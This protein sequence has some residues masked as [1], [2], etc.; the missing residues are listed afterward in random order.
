[1]TGLE[2]DAPP[3][4]ETRPPR[5]ATLR[6]AVRVQLRGT[7]PKLALGWLLLVVLVSA[8]A[9]FVEPQNPLAQHLI[10]A[11]QGPSTAHWLGTDEYGRDLL[12]RLI[13]GGGYLL[14]VS[15]LPVAISFG[16][17]V[18][19]GLFAGYVGGRWD[20][21]ASFYVNVL[22]SVPAMVV[23]LATAAVTNQSLPAMCL[24][25][26]I[27]GTSGILRISR[28]STLS[29]RDLLYV[30]AARVARL[31]RRRILARHILPNAAGPLLVQAFLVYS[32]TVLFLSSLAFLQLGFDPDK[33]NWGEMAY[34]ASEHL[35]NDPW[36]MVPIGTVL[37]L[38]VYSVTFLGNRLLRALP[39]A[40]RV[41]LLTAFAPLDVSASPAE[42]PGPQDALLQVSGL[43]VTFP[44]PDGEIATVDDVGFSVLRG[45]VLG[46]VGE[47]GSGKS[48]IGRALLGLVEPAAGTLRLDGH[49]LI[50]DRAAAAHLL[51]AVFQD[52]YSSLNPARTVGATLTEP[53]EIH[54]RLAADQAAE[55][56]SGLLALVAL[57]ADTARRYP[58]AFSGGQRQRIGV[59][60][61][62]SV[63]PRLVICDEATSALDLVT[64]ARV[65]DLLGRLQRERGLSYLFIAHNLPLV[66]RFAHRVVVLYRGRVME[67]GPA[68]AVCSEPLHPYSRAL[69]AATPV[70]DP[71]EQRRRREKRAAE[72]VALTPV[73]PVPDVGC[74]FAPRCPKAFEPCWSHRP[75]DTVVGDR[76]LACHLYHPSS[77]ERNEP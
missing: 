17:G 43:T 12:S 60:R 13:G 59:A 16:L 72:P 57:P 3:P 10:D 5:P 15:L 23:I 33:P 7:G 14:A 31:P 8:L 38:T 68:S 45:A 75:A 51:Q 1:M 24:V 67:Q 49:D 65:I 11:Y 76:T 37:V 39:S 44:S 36:L 54:R 70:R 64:Q 34:D 22:F 9:T 48:T 25:F 18:P 47:S 30:D 66:A 28:A 53:L 62:L 73:R 32:G 63:E 29:V 69:I 6:Q 56:I 77:T 21:A 74:P 27:L 50:A 46:L 61:A 41:S 52:P 4:R 20:A 35:Q 58:H 40:Q 71:V 2:S 42:S 26:G 19:A 55:D